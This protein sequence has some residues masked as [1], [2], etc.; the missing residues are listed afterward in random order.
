LIKINIVSNL[1]ENT[2]SQVS[3]RSNALIDSLVSD[4]RALGV[5]EEGLALMFL[6]Q[7]DSPRMRVID[8]HEV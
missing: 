4:L 2:D 6:V 1:P 7:R 8:S 3:A 5:N